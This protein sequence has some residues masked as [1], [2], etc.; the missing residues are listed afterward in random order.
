MLLELVDLFLH[1]VHE[2][3]GRLGLGC[4]EE[5]VVLG[6]LDFLPEPVT[7]TTQTIRSLARSLTS[8]SGSP[9]AFLLQT[10]AFLG[11]TLRFKERIAGI[12]E[13]LLYDGTVL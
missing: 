6:D 2:F 1:R 8:C 5:D 10:L 12:G 7:Q 13:L 9:F 4:K 3:I 11:F